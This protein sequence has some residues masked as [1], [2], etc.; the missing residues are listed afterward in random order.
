MSTQC[1]LEW[2][3]LDTAFRASGLTLALSG[4]AVSRP[5]GDGLQ[6]PCSSERSERQPGPGKSG[7]SRPQGDGLQS[8]AAASAA[9]GNPPALQS[10]HALT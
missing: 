6:S 3:W 5:K 10:A 8:P 7:V 1:S 4:R 2:L 9:S